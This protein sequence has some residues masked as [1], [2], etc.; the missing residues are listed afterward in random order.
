MGASMEGPARL[1]ADGIRN[2]DFNS[3]DFEVVS[4]IS[5]VIRTSRCWQDS[6]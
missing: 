6:N 2:D 4:R 3:R 5:D 1:T